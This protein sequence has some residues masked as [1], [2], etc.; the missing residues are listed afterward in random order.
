MDFEG[1]HDNTV[2][3]PLTETVQVSWSKARSWHGDTVT[4]RVRTARV[5]SGDNVRLE[6]H[7]AG[8]AAF[9]TLPNQPIQNNTLDYD[10]QLDWKTMVIPPGSMFEV[11]AHLVELNLT[12]ARSEPMAVDLIPPLFSA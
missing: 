9:H 2:P 1:D 7:V 4:I 3:A 5:R 8:G 12:S 10:Y 6:I 11:T